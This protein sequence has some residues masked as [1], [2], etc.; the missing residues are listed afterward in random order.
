MWNVPQKSRRGGPVG[1]GA[2]SGGRAALDALDRATVGR[3][4]SNQYTKRKP[5]EQYDNVTLP[6]PDTGNS[7]TYALRKLRK[8]RPDLHE[9]VLGGKIS[10]HDPTI[11]NRSY[12]LPVRWTRRGAA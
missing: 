8:A 9:R 3:H 2:S 6:K 10:P 5:T 11:K 1:G 12:C 7:N 4:G